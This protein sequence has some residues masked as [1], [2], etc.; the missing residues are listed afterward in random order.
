MRIVPRKC[1]F[2]VQNSSLSLVLM[3]KWGRIGTF[4]GMLA[5]AACAGPVDRP[6]LG[7]GTAAPS[8]PA[9]P[10]VDAGSG[11][12]VAEAPEPVPA[13]APVWRLRTVLNAAALSC[14]LAGD[15][16]LVARYNQLLRHHRSALAIAY[17]AEQDRYRRQHGAGWQRV[18]DTEMTR[19]YNHYGSIGGSPRF[20]AAA[21]SIAGDAIAADADALPRLAATVLPALLGRQPRAVGR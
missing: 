2:R 6:G 10:A 21:A 7:V 13:M 3:S 14:R 20:C 19:I 17:A 15:T 1:S 8:I 16:Q 18:Q 12:P 11:A 4:A 9:K 5:L